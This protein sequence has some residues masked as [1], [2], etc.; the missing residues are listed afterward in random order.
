MGK[1]RNTRVAPLGA[2]QGLPLSSFHRLACKIIIHPD[3]FLVD[4]GD[5]AD[6]WTPARWTPMAAPDP[7]WPFLSVGE[8]LGT[9]RLQY[10]MV[11]VLVRL[12]WK[13]QEERGSC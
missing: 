8:V 5:A 13:V 11:E 3:T 9:G 12:F 10:T 2:T 6:L 4:P 1:C 7:P